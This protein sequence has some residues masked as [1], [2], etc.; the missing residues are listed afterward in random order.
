MDDFPL[1]TPPQSPRFDDFYDMPLVEI[2]LEENMDTEGKLCVDDIIII[3]ILL[4]NF[5]ESNINLIYFINFRWS[6]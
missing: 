4:T 5:L 6:F 3:V 2:D 1:S